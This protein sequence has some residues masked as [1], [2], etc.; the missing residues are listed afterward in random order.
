MTKD[1]FR[2][3]VD[4]ITTEWIAI[5]MENEEIDMQTAMARTL[6]S[7]T[8]Q[9]LCDASTALSWQRAGYVYELSKQVG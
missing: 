3:L 1:D 5:M 8:Y 6:G 2:F 7:H 4:C 9:V